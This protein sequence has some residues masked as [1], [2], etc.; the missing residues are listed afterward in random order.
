MALK[1]LLEFI[2]DNKLSGE[3]KKYADPSTGEV[4]CV[5]LCCDLPYQYMD[6]Y[7]QKL[8]EH[9]FNPIS[10]LHLKDIDQGT[11][12][13]HWELT[14]SEAVTLNHGKPCEY[15]Q[16]GADVADTHTSAVT[17]I[18]LRQQD[19][20]ARSH[21]TCSL[22]L[23]IRS[24]EIDR[25]SPFDDIGVLEA[26]FRDLESAIDGLYLSDQ[27]PRHGPVLVLCYSGETSRLA[28]S[29][30]RQKSIEA[31]SLRGGFQQL[32]TSDACQTRP[33]EMKL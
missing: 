23:P 11:Y 3:L 30:M 18:D 9:D 33:L 5:F 22:N 29:I 6:T 26:Q 13:S 17:V 12:D 19:D 8:G 16:L 32:P 24:S 27:P 7:F 15:S 14:V 21:V 10:N 25:P 20:F 2:E 1:G 4:S 31:Y 28:C